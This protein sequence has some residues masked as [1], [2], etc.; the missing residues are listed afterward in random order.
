MGYMRGGN[1]LRVDLGSGKIVKEPTANYEKLWLGG[2]G[3]N[4]RILYTETDPSID[5]LDPANVLMFSLGPF[6]GTMVPGSGRV[7]VSAKSP[8]SGIQGM[9]N[10][11]GYWGPELKYAGYDSIILKGKAAN[12]PK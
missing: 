12:H 9:S 5:P 8:V 3:L 4:S 2:R 7:E 11:G 10:M 6:T 1:I